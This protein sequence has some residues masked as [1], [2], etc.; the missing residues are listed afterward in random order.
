M[1]VYEL[2]E[3]R[4]PELNYVEKQVKKVLDLV[5]VELSGSKSGS[6]TRLMT[7]YSRLDKSA[8]LL[9]E[10]REATNLEMK[11]KVADLFDAADEVLTRVVETASFTI[12]LSKAEKGADKKPKTSIDYEA[13]VKELQVMVPEL[14]E[15]IKEIT[16]KFTEI[17]PAKDSPITLRVRS[18]VDEGVVGDIL[19]SVK[20]FAKSI[21]S[22]LKSYDRRLAVL[23]SK[24]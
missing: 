8:A 5:T 13:I 7:R 12:T 10:R 23:K 2:F 1:K 4:N 11:D 19:K 9:A 15:K 16:K 3:A 20:A 24:I 18:K 21:F 14:E 6:M 22:W 17:T